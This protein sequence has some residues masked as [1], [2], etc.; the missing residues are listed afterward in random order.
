[1][2]DGFNLIG[3]NFLVDENFSIKFHQNSFPVKNSPERLKNG[4]IYIC[5]DGTADIEVDFIH[6]HIEKGMIFSAF[7]LQIMEQKSVSKNFSLIYISCAPKILQNV[8]LRFPP[9]F[10]TFLKRTPAYKAPKKTYKNGIEL[11]NLIKCKFE[12]IDNICRSEMIVNMLRV[13]YLEIYND[14]HNKISKKF[15][16]PSRKMEIMKKFIDL[17]MLNNSQ[18]RDVS[19]YA[20]KLNITPKYLS[21]VTQQFNGIGA[22][23]FIDFYTI[24]AIKLELKS[25]SK[26]IQEISEVLNFPDQSFFCKY[27]KNHTGLTPKQFRSNL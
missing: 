13:Y 26:T 21:I 16:E 7:P 22:K 5:T 12:E 19:F 15:S 24:T 27:F 18:F 4:F 11:F 25:T 17:I 2:I 14:I 6:Y 10:E 9:E 8:L 3:S 20:G 23:K 1:M